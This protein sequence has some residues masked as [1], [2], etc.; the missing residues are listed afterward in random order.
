MNGQLEVERRWYMEMLWGRISYNPQT[1]D[2]VFKN[3]LAKRYPGVSADNLFEAWS[4]ASGA[5]P[6]V[7]ELIMGKWSLDFHWYPEGC[8]SDPGRG[9]GFRTIDG[10]ANETTVAKGSNLCDIANSA[11]GTCDGK[12]SSYTVADEMQADAEKALSLIKNIKAGGNADLEMAIN[13]VKQMANLG[14]YYAHKVRGATYKKAGQTDKAREEMAKAYCWWISYTRLM[15]VTYY[16]DS[17][18]NHEIKPDWKY[19]DAAALKEYTDL[20]G[21]GIPD[22]K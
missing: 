19:A 12:K 17:F 3:L 22:C 9:T 18:R 10:M 16:G 2:D 4:L 15:E 6:K 13:N 21:V 7:T 20:G 1:S 8:W 14:V 11:A 5:L